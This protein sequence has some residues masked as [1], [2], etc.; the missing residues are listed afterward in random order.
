MLLSF[1]FASTCMPTFVHRVPEAPERPAFRSSPFTVW[2]LDNRRDSDDIV[3][4]H[5]TCIKTR[6]LSFNRRDSK[7]V[8]HVLERSRLSI[9]LLLFFYENYI[10]ESKLVYPFLKITMRDCLIIF[11]IIA[12]FCIILWEYHKD[13]SKYDVIIYHYIIYLF[14]Y[15]KN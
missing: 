4:Q 11:Y 10:V 6:K 1:S 7:I 2:N 8:S 12:L 5:R 3:S 14:I 9:W 13:H 15:F